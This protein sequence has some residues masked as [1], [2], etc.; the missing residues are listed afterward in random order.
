MDIAARLAENAKIVNER[1][2]Y[3]LTPGQH[4]GPPEKLA[5][6]MRHAVMGGGKRIRPFLLMESARMFGRAPERCA[7][8]AAALECLHCYSLVHDDLPAMDDDD[9]RR[10]R[11]TVHK[12]FDEAT[13]ILAGDALQSLAFELI[14]HPRCHTDPAV[15]ARLALEL[16]AASGWAGM[17][18]GQMMDLENEGRGKKARLAI[19]QRIH[20]MK[21]AALIEFSC[22]AGGVLAEA[23]EDNIERLR[24]FGQLL[25][26]MFQG[27]DD[28]L[29]ATASSEEIGKTAGKDE[30]AGKATIIARM[31]LEKARSYVDGLKRA[32]LEE[33]APFGERAEW[34][35]AAARFVTER[36]H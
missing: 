6:A 16:A 21:T 31:G 17:A 3:H 12:A 11:P 32:A 10:G 33:L 13:A 35:A 15:R 5:N 1:L 26:L 14:A 23:D 36:G 29:D 30:A 7:E 8:A 28:I 9:M 4:F 24:R 27:A 19:I 18:G 22:A 20:D 34:L 25:G 2:N